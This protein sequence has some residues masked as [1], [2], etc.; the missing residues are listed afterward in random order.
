M[1]CKWPFGYDDAMDA[2]SADFLK[3]TDD[4]IKALQSPVEKRKTYLFITLENMRLDVDDNLRRLV[5]TN[6]AT[7]NALIKHAADIVHRHTYALLAI[8][9]DTFAFDCDS[10]SLLTSHRASH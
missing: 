10:S 7:M 8:I 6:D 4:I 3:Y 2:V 5:R 9:G 1:Y